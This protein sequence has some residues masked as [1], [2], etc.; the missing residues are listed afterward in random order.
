MEIHQLR[1]RRAQPTVSPSGREVNHYGD[2]PRS[3]SPSARQDRPKAKAKVQW[4][5]CTVWAVSIVAVIFLMS[6]TCY[7]FMSV[8]RVTVKQQSLLPLHSEQK[9]KQS[10]PVPGGMTTVVATVYAP[11][12]FGIV[13]GEHV[14]VQ[15]E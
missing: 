3:L 4:L 7:R 15:H 8:G 12:R 5:I 6:A 13:A 2:Q 1:H 14:T 9:Q 10:F 11:H